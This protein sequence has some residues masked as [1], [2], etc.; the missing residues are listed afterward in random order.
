MFFAH[1]KLFQ[2]RVC[3]ETFICPV[4]DLFFGGHL[5]LIKYTLKFT[6]TVVRF[7][8]AQYSNVNV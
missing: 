6:T 3:I 2:N 4:T 7:K 5:Y 8:R 1:K